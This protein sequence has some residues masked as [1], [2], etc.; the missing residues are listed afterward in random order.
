M[1]TTD[2][3]E[4]AHALEDSLRADVLRAIADGS[5]FDASECARLAVSTAELDFPRWYA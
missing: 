5:C 3:S 1:E 2:D 4:T